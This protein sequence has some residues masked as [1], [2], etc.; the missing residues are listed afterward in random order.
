MEGNGGEMTIFHFSYATG[1]T[2]KPRQYG[3]LEATESVHIRS[4]H[5]RGVSV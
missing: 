5:I 3:H 2:V 4:L 1:N